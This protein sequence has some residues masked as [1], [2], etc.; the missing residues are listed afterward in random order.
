MTR[1]L[2]CIIGQVRSADL[3]W[4]R[5][6]ARVLRPLDADLALAVAYGPP[7]P[8][9]N[10]AKY[11]WAW[12]EPDDYGKALDY[13]SRDM[14]VPNMWR[15]LMGL[16][17]Y[18]IGGVEE[19]KQQHPQGR[20]AASLFFWRWWL[21]RHLQHIVDEYD[22]FI[23]TRSDHRWLCP[24]RTDY[25][26]DHIWLPDDAPDRHQIV[27]REYV[28]RLVRCMEWLWREPELA[29]AEMLAHGPQWSQTE[30]FAF[31]DAC[32]WSYVHAGLTGVIRRYPFTFFSVSHDIGEWSDGENCY[33][34]Y[35][36]ERDTAYINAQR[37]EGACLV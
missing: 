7:T 29:Y 14:G 10:A 33:V 12:K 17:G 11:V 27:G 20:G 37:Q 4:D 16:P 19:Y 31:E 25:N 23:I 2:V 28:E 13:V 34:K 36:V 30:E 26:L 9:H 22:Q 32:D 21:W 8:Y 5:F 18:W 24:H 6:R 35:T 3:T 15:C 1:T